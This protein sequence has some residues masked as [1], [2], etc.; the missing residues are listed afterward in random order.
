MK[1]EGIYER[2]AIY[3]KKWYK[4]DKEL[5]LGAEPPCIKNC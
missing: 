4:N 3:V 5:D 2:S 1:V